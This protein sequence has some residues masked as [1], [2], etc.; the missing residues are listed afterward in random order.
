MLQL[1][2]LLYL[3][4]SQV[5]GTLSENGT[6]IQKTFEL[7]KQGELIVLTNQKDVILVFG[8]TE[9]GKSTLIQWI[10]GDNT[11]IDLQ[12]DLPRL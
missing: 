7:L 4:L 8:A 5:P 10:A 3:C 2:L 12:R 6:E 9:A 11:K 1:V